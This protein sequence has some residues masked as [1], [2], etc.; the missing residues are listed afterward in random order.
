MR[1]LLL[2]GASR[3]LRILHGFG[4][5]FRTPTPLQAG[6]SGSMGYPLFRQPLTLVSVDVGFVCLYVWGYR[7]VGLSVW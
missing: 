6:G 1:A 5:G 7:F 4:L 2:K 3:G